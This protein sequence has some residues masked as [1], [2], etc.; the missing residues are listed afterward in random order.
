MKT[1]ARTY[2]YETANYFGTGE[3]EFKARYDDHKNYSHHID[4]IAAVLS[5]PLCT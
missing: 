1:N 4:E 3:G 5:N 2:T